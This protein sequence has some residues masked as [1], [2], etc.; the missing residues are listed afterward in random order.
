MKKFLGAIT[1]VLLMVLGVVAVSDNYGPPGQVHKYCS[2]V[3]GQICRQ[4]E[5]S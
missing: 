2:I 3:G 4:I 1:L 5:Q